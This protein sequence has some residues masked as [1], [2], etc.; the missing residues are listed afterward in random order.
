MR[1]NGS[2]K[3][4][5]QNNKKS[6]Q[7]KGS[8]TKQDATIGKKVLLF[9]PVS[10]DANFAPYN[11]VKEAFILEVQKLDLK[12]KALMVKSLRDEKK[13][14][15]RAMKPLKY[16]VSYDTQS[17]G[18]RVETMAVYS[19]RVIQEQQRVTTRA[20]AQQGQQGNAP[21][22]Q[23]PELSEALK[24]LVKDHQDDKDAEFE[25][26]KKRVNE[27]EQHYNNDILTVYAELWQFIATVMRK[28]LEGLEDY[29]TRIHNDPVECLMEIKVQINDNT[30]SIHPTISMMNAVRRMLSMQQEPDQSVADYQKAF[31]ARM[32]VVET[33]A[34]NI[35][36]DFIG[37][38]WKEKLDAIDRDS[39]KSAQE[40]L[41]AK[42]KLTQQGV[43]ES[44]AILF[45]DNA[46]KT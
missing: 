45:I 46:D 23:E 35:F 4:K 14:D 16:K 19:R 17:S 9:A 42:A 33:Q 3:G 25:S 30:Y 27:L 24:E 22:Q 38:Q 40:K 2:H 15:F 12:S 8:D 37:I 10:K 26:E 34:G 20:A 29:Q 44:Y 6:S 5:W 41:N 43:D 28:R 32:D 31:Q 13:P 21:A 18:L 39:S 1:N 36:A 11:T 7:K